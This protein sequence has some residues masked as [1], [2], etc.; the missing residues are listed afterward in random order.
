MMMMQFLKIIAI[1]WPRNANTATVHAVFFVKIQKSNQNI[2]LISQNR[3]SVFNQ[4]HIIL[5]V[6]QQVY[7]LPSL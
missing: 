6:D 7:F 4:L 5:P 2:F 3:S 1:M